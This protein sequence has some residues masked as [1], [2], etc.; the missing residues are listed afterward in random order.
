MPVIIF[1][2]GSKKKYKKFISIRKVSRDFKNINKNY[3]ISALLNNKIVDLSTI[4]NKDSKLFF[5][6]KTDEMALQIIRNT[7]LH[8]L[9]YSL[10]LLWPEIKLCQSFV[11][12]PQFYYDFYKKI[13]LTEKDISLI[14][15]KMNFLIKKKY[16]IFLKKMDYKNFKKILIDLKE[17][18]KIKILKLNFKKKDNISF[19]IHEKNIDFLTGVQAPKISFCKYFKLQK[20]SGVYWKSNSKNQM[21]Q[22]ISGTAWANKLQ[23]KSFLKI[24]KSNKKIDHRFI[25]KKLNLFHLQ[26]DSPGMVFWHH[27]G[28]FIF[29]K[30]KDFIR[31][32]LIK[33]KYQEVKTPFL[34]NKSIWKK[35]GHLENYQDFIF[36]TSSENKEYCIKPMNC[37]GH[38]QIF[39]NFLK[40]YKDL[41]IRI[42]EFGS[43]HRNEF[44][45]SLHGLMRLRNFTQDDAHI[46]CT[47]SQL[48]NEIKN[49]IKMIYEIYNTFSFNKILVKLS[50][51]PYKRI[52]NNSVWD[53]TEKILINVLKD[54]KIKFSIQK[55]E[56]AFYGPKIEFELRDCF[57]RNW[58]C[59][60][61]QLDFY[62]S[63][64]LGSFYVNKN[65]KKKHPVLIHRAILGSIERFIG[66]LLE[67]YNG[68]LPIW[69]VPIQVKIINVS[70]NHIEYC[71]NILKLLQKKNIRTE[72]DF[73]NKTI[74]LKIRET[75]L[76]K[77][78][79]ILICGD[80]ELQNNTVSVRYFSGKMINNINLLEFINKINKKINF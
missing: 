11:N 30:L 39:N 66:I 68:F 48:K 5:I 54:S 40:S 61:I 80:K 29:K 31:K 42:S 27:N 6:K 15:K 17:T 72:T 49:C 9:G 71:Q 77:I 4:I 47:K 45:G 7:C 19:Y 74:G 79:Y 36:S 13:P 35:S 73:K 50:T 28:W 16:N 69:L 26:K 22:R 12:E 10:K 21:I 3:Y 38:I 33:Y 78:P 55:G 25:S 52:G 44:S 14:E 20:L 18:Y 62:L 24:L 43:C 75:V 34:M 57:N 53:Y 8:L 56:G 60:T 51:R 1:S 65:N 41:P 59:G 37:P 46:F 70:E 67:E 58:Q 32:K 63:K 76:L 2:D 64:R 23:L